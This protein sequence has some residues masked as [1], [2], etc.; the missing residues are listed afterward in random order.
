MTATR[1]VRG[2][3]LAVA[4]AIWVVLAGLLWHTTVPSLRLPQLD[5]R[6]VFG[7]V[8]VQRAERY[9]R[10]LVWDW[11]AGTLATLVA[12]VIVARRART[13]APRLGLRPVNTGIVLGM[14][15]ITIVWAVGVPFA[16]A[17][18]WWERRHHISREGYGD[19]VPAQW[20]R[21]L[22]TAFMTLVLLGI[23]LLFAR[24]LGRRWWVAA[25]PTIAAVA[26][27]L[28]FVQ[29]FLASVGTK[30]LRSSALRASVA[31]LEAVEHAGSPSVRVD[32]VG[33]RTR[34]ANAFAVGF[35]PSAHVVIW[36][37]LLDGRFTFSQ[38]RFV[39]A[40]EL[41]HL[42]HK[43][44]LRGVAWFSL[45]LLPV[46]AVVA[47]TADLRR[48]SAVPLALLV[49]A[50]AQLALLPVQNAVSRRIETE[51]DWTALNATRDPAAARGLFRGFVVTSLEDPSPPGW[52]HVL[53]DDH[54]SPLQ[55]V[56]LGAAWHSATKS[57]SAAPS[58][59]DFVA[60]IRYPLRG[61]ARV[62]SPRAPVPEASRSRA[63]AGRAKPSRT[64]SRN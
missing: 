2:A 27:L 6:A 47:Y 58:H 9:E 50:V 35:G 20:G 40:H 44:I 13:I 26:L 28:Q 14:L 29:P 51:A 59:D 19:Q 55:R 23:L 38:V 41:G 33:G 57:G 3:T 37:T 45:L 62:R 48:G 56:E 39:I 63:G 11:V 4:A 22:A 54:P 12:Y 25:A 17:G 49:I 60:I 18:V 8:L 1:I 5:E 42:A 10:F 30:P 32:D 16:V 36:S 31:H 52:V 15:T 34:E 61:N 43:H 24:R 7:A 21:L 64:L 46:L 53:L